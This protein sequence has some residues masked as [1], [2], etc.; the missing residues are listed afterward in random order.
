MH[1]QVANVL[2]TPEGTT[3]DGKDY[4]GKHQIQLLCEEVLRNG[5]K[6]L[7]LFTLNT[8]RPDDYKAGTVADV[9]VGVFVTPKGVQFYEVK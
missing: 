2:V 4:G 8:N 7:Q 5:E 1:G 6:R 9:P 3:R